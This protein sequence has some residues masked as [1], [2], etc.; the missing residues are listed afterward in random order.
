METHRL[1]RTGREEPFAAGTARTCWELH[2]VLAVG[3]MLV[4]SPG[5][6]PWLTW[7]DLMFL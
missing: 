6:A 7:D 2:L 3:L 5:Q 4:R 1:R